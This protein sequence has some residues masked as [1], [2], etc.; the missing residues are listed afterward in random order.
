MYQSVISSV[1]GLVHKSSLSHGHTYGTEV[2]RSSVFRH[3]YKAS[4]HPAL[5]GKST[6]QKVASYDSQSKVLRIVALNG[7]K[8]S[9]IY[10][11]N[12]MC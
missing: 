2:I 4:L 5:I 8:L 9:E 1:V 6:E 12:G 7:R 3:V 11:S 10:A